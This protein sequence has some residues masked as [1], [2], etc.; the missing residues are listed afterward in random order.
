[1][2][3]ATH[4]YEEIDRVEKGV[5][6]FKRG[7]IEAFGK[8][9]FDS[10]RSS[11]ENYQTGSDELKTIYDIMLNTDGVYGGR[12]SGA[13]FRGCCIALIAPDF[14]D[15]VLKNVK[16][17]YLKAFPKLSDNYADAICESSDGIL[18]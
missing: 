12:F 8:L 6:A 13:G 10:G 7:D 9:V 4:Y 18:I 3:R 14:E 16:E 17:K 1:M 15:Y 2:L 5:E 11:I